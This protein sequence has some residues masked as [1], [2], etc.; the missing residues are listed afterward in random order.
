ML[1]GLCNAQATFQ[2]VMDKVVN[3]VTKLGHP[4]ID[5]Y[6]DNILVYSESFEKH[7]DT[8]R[9]VFVVT[10]ESNLSL[11]IDKCEFAKAQVELLGFIIDGTTV[12]PTPYNVKKGGTVPSTRKKLQRFFGLLTLIESSLAIVLKW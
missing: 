12:R 2:R 4:G 10:K 1:F 11:R 8:L 6:L 9:D 3:K 5:A 7:M